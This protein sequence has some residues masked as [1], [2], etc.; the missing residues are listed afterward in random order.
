MNAEIM[1]LIQE[2]GISVKDF[3]A[4]YGTRL[5]GIESYLAKLG[6]RGITAY[7]KSPSSG[8]ANLGEFAQSVANAMRPGGRTDERLLKIQAIATGSGEVVPADGGFLVGKDLLDRVWSVTTACHTEREKGAVVERGR[9]HFCGQ[10]EPIT[11]VNGGMLLFQ[12]KERFVVLDRPVG[13][14]IARKFHRLSE[15]IQ[16]ALRRFSF[17]L[18]F[19]QLVLADGMTCRLHQTGIDGNAFIDG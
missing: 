2:M 19:P 16:A 13:I 18:F 4:E 5:D 3:K 9:G 7:E 6:A 8:F 17:D 1:T 12:A 10:N 15:P 14:E 11:G